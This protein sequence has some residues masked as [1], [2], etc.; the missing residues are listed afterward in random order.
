VSKEKVLQIV[1]LAP[2]DS[3]IERL[4]EMHPMRQV[5]WA[6]IVQILVLGFMGVA[7]TT[8]HYFIS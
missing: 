3:I 1:N 6:T 4:I 7:M 5:A 2:N 8:I